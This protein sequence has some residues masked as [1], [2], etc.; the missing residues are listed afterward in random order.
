MDKNTNTFTDDETKKTIADIADRVHLN[1]DVIRALKQ[2]IRKRVKEVMDP[3]NHPNI[4]NEEKETAILSQA[5]LSFSLKYLDQSFFQYFIFEYNIN[6]DIYINLD[7]EH[8]TKV[9]DDIFAR[10]KLNEDLR[11]ELEVN[12]KIDS[13]KLKV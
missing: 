5:L 13:K 1:I 6:E 7:S 11:A 8:K 3:Q 12:A 10:K 4:T 2:N 9:V